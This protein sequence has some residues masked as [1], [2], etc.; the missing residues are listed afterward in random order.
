MRERMANKVMK[1]SLRV[2]L[3]TMA[4]ILVFNF[5]FH[6][7]FVPMGLKTPLELKLAAHSAIHWTNIN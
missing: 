4:H 3:M 6:F 5:V 1:L 2:F 7:N